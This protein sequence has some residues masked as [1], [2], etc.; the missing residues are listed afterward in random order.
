[1]QTGNSVPEE[2]LAKVLNYITTTAEYQRKGYE[3]V[4]INS[5]SGRWIIDGFPA[6]KKQAEALEAV[7][8]IPNQVFWLGQSLVN[9]L[10]RADQLD[11]QSE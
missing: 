8:L 9:G 10:Q 6:T 4:Y 11:I 5:N 2:V 1:L 3:K 7:G